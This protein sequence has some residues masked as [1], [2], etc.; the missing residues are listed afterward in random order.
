MINLLQIK[1][2]RTTPY[3]PQSHGLAEHFNHTFYCIRQIPLGVERPH[4]LVVL[5]MCITLIFTQG[6]AIPILLDVG[7]H[8]ELPVNLVLILVCRQ[9]WPLFTI[10]ML[11]HYSTLYR[12]HADIYVCEECKAKKF[13]KPPSSGPHSGQANANI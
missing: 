9:K 11:K 12:T 1:K 2:T 3:H 7:I 13:H 5:H 6:L 4:L 8:T 10:S